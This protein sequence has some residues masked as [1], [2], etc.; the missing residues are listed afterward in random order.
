VQERLRNGRETIGGGR[1]EITYSRKPNIMFDGS[2]RY[3]RG[4]EVHGSLICI[5][6]RQKRLTLFSEGDMVGKI[7]RTRLGGVT[8]DQ[9]DSSAIPPSEKRGFLDK[10]ATRE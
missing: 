1:G 2:I 9:R 8:I 6:K 4:R 5:A 7:A 10:T 3:K